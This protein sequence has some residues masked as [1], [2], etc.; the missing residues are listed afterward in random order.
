M[1]VAELQSVMPLNVAFP[2]TRGG[3][4]KLMVGACRLFVKPGNQDQWV[5]GT[6][7]D[8]TGTLPC[9]VNREGET[10]V[11]S[12]EFS[13]LDLMYRFDEPPTFRLVLG[14]GTPFA[15][16]VGTG[17]SEVN[18]DLGGLSLTRVEVKHGAGKVEVDFSAPNPVPMSLLEVSSGAGAT[19]FYNLANANCSEMR[20][21][22]GAAGYVMDFGGTLRRDF[23]MKIQAALAAIDIS[24]PESIS[25]RVMPEAVMGGVEA[26][27]AWMQR[28]GVFLTL[29][30]L[31]DKTPLLTIEA[32]VVMGSVKLRAT[33]APRRSTD[34]STNK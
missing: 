30:A 2:A 29:G 1:S 5:T 14:K 18:L 8:P 31:A 11:I 16:T 3:H 10:V 17:A 13:P 12:Q 22:G 19:E 34:T 24:I 28:D 20:V 15:L 4:L 7:D 6:Y 32:H 26:G 23:H 27:D 9:R 25:A 21:E 33:H